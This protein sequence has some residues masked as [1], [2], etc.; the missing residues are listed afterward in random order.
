MALHSTFGFSLIAAE[1]LIGTDRAIDLE[2]CAFG[3]TIQGVARRARSMGLV[4]VIVTSLKRRKG[5]DSRSAED[6]S[7]FVRVEG[8][9]AGNILKP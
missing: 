9:L 3:S 1:V 6:L 2:V 8:Q 4:S 5:R 7:R